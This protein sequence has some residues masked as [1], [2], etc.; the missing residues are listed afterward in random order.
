VAE[1]RERA[2]AFAI[3]D[4]DEHVSEDDGEVVRI[5]LD[6]MYAAERSVHR[7]AAGPAAI[8]R[9]RRRRRDVALLVV[10]ALIGVLAYRIRLSH[11][12]HVEASGVYNAQFEAANAIDGK[13]ETEWLMPD[14]VDRGWLDV[15]LG[16]ERAVTAVRLLN[17]HNPPYNDRAIKDYELQCFTGTSLVRSARGTFVWS[18]GPDWVDVPLDGA[19]CDL[20]RLV[21]ASKHHNGGALAEIQVR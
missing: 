4:L 16:K 18:D 19:T 2:G 3:P 7:L 8:V 9:I 20:V 6:T 1:L 21:V 15:Y 10:A 17:G 14:G 12:L 5:L 11:T 13:R